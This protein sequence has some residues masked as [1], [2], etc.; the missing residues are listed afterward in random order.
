LQIFTCDLDTFFIRFIHVMGVRVTIEQTHI[1]NASRSRPRLIAKIAT[2]F[3]SIAII[4]WITVSM[5]IPHITNP[6]PPATLLNKTVILTDENYEARYPLNLTKGEKI[7]V[8]VSGNGQPV[9]FRITDNLSTT[10]I[11][12]IGIMF[13][14]LPWMVPGDGTYVFCVSAPIGDV[15]ATLV[16][17]EA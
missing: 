15:T 17:A 11:E 6:P 5:L 12:E 2:I 3:V 10:L 9:D 1:T 16:V 7:D 14:D 4:A 8:K 13:Y